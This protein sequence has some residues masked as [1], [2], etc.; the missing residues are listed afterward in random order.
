MG[1]DYV[2]GTSWRHQHN[3]PRQW[4][5][6]LQRGGTWEGDGPRIPAAF[7]NVD[8]RRQLADARESPRAERSF[9]EAGSPSLRGGSGRGAS[10]GV[11]YMRVASGT[12]TEALVDSIREGMGL[13]AE[14]R[15]AAGTG[16]SSPVSLRR[17]ASWSEHDF[18]GSPTRGERR[19]EAGSVRQQ[20]TRAALGQASG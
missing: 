9:A 1:G 6:Q 19:S 2:E 5:G 10:G 12:D 7:R 18:G 3:G 16:Q 15:R 13:P 8:A 17:A 4:A 11:R 20:G 14:P